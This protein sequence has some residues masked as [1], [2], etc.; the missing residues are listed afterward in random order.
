MAKP[1]VMIIGGGLAG[2][3]A[4]IKLAELEC[5]V[6]IMS[7]LPLKRAHSVCAQG[8]INS[9]NDLTRQLGDSEWKHFE[10][11]VYGGDFLQHQPPV[12]ELAYWAPRIIDLMDRLG[13]TF[14]RT[15]EGFRDQRRFGGTLYQRTAFAGATTGQQLVYALD[16]QIRRWEVTGHI[17]KFEYWDFL[18]PVIDEMGRC[19]GCVGQDLVSMEIRAFPADAL[20]IGSGGCGAIYGRSTNSV[21]CNGAAVSRVYQAGGRYGNGEFIQVHPT[22]IPGADKLRLISES[23]RGEGGRVWVPRKPQDPRQPQE[24][25]ENERYYFLE[26]RYPKYGNLVPRDIGTRE[27]FKVCMQEGLSVQAGRMCVYLDVTHIPRE[28]LD[29]KLAGILEIYEKFQG[30]DPR[31]VPMKIFPAVHYTMGGLWVDYEANGN[32][33]LNIGSPRNQQTNIPGL[34]AIGEC[35]Y[36]YHGANRLGANSLVACIFSG[37]TVAPGI[38]NYVSSFNG[39]KSSELPSGVFDQAKRRH[40]EY[41]DSLLKRPQGGPNPYKVHAELGR[42][43][44]KSATV[45]RHN[46]DMQETYAKVSELQQQAACCSISDTSTWTN[47]T[48]PFARAL[49]DMFPVAKAILQGA[50]ARDESRGA[51]YKP[52]FAQGEITATEPAQRRREAEAWIDRFEANNR[53]WLKSTIAA[54]GAGGEPSLSYED[55][56]TSLIPPRPRLYGLAGGDVIEQMFKQRQAAVKKQPNPNDE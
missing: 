32:G 45:V 11:T 23:A 19:R 21:A 3:A 43:M 40:Q 22:A 36:Q 9:V 39:Q 18:G 56:N 27:I 51:H 48:A 8:G 30:A 49:E 31:K 24:I 53:K 6:S 50:I 35:E 17:R 26:E 38:I 15:P 20:V 54:C 25:P 7:L 10:D 28:Q 13:V 12:K 47:Q 44:T 29:R 1:S 52:E 46:A 16:E 2:M 14:N 4:A 41:Y 37:L 55:V 5:D 33:G 34:Y 42:L